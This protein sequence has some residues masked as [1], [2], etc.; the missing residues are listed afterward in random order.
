[1]RNQ[2]KV[3]KKSEENTDN[4]TILAIFTMKAYLV[5]ATHQNK[6]LL[7]K[8]QRSHNDPMISHFLVYTKI[9]RPN[10]YKASKKAIKKHSLTFQH[11]SGNFGEMAL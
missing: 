11:C 1:M 9:P 2:Q 8:R 5:T 6:E 10:S 3:K 7:L 4:F